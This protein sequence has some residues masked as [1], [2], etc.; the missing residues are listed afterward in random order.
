MLSLHFVKYVQEFSIIPRPEGKAID[1]AVVTPVA[2]NY[3]TSQIVGFEGVK[4]L[5]RYNGIVLG[6]Y[7]GGW[8]SDAHQ[9]IIEERIAPEVILPIDK[10]GI[11][12]QQDICHREAGVELQDIGEIILRW[13]ERLF[14]PE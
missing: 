3:Q 8:N 10:L 4:I 7:D 5:N 12:L 11:S 1:E 9:G 14:L 13:E 2:V 6:G